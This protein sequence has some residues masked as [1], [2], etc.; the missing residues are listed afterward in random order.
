M[1]SRANRGCKSFG[2]LQAPKW[3]VP[4]SGSVALTAIAV[5]SAHLRVHAAANWEAGMPAASRQA[6]QE[7][8]E[9]AQ[10]T[11]PGGL[12]SVE[13]QNPQTPPSTIFGQD[14]EPAE[15]WPLQETRRNDQ[16]PVR[17]PF[18]TAHL[19]PPSMLAANALHVE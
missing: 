16:Q 13:V 11:D 1:G 2:A 10:A 6:G 7:Q 18:V 3:S 8:A 9:L 5:Q 19:T 4:R 17:H 12:Q 15:E 14:Y